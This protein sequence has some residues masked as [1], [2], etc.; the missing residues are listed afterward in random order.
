M[1]TV[2]GALLLVVALLMVQVSPASARDF[3]L[4]FERGKSYGVMSNS[5]VR[6][7]RDHYYFG[8]NVGQ[9]L[10]VGISSVED[11]AV[12]ELYVKSGGE[13]FP[14]EQPVDTRVLYG[15]LPESEGGQYRLTVG[16]TR[17]NAS[18]DL[19]VGISAAGR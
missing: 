15:A 12:V 9:M 5:V 11:N 10:T 19:F 2:L 18:Y 13:W 17:G 8:A 16:G 4:T 1:R 7:D 6:G 14:V 3:D